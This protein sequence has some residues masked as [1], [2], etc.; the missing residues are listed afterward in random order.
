MNKLTAKHF[1]ARLKQANLA[2]E[3]DIANFKKKRELGNKL[4][5]FDKR[6]NSN[7]TK[8]VLVENKLNE[9]KKFIFLS[10]KYWIFYLDRICFTSND[11]SQN[12]F[13]LSTNTWHFRI[14]GD[15]GVDCVLSLKTNGV[16]S[17]KL[18]PLSN[19]FWQCMKLCGYGIGKNFDKVPLAV[20]KKII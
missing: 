14:K 18:E 15:K 6:I 4:L 3:S 7:K 20:E 12:T 13:F 9:L 2:S 17:Y 10:R 19:A 16:Y 1:D 8:H 5:S 11:G